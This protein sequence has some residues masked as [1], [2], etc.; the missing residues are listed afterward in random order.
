MIYFKDKNSAVSA[1]TKT[2]LLQVDRATELE[3]LLAEKEPVFLEAK[4]NV[5][6]AAKALNEAK[7]KLILASEN[8]E[9]S[10]DDEEIS[11]EYY[12]EIQRVSLLVDTETNKYNEALAIFTPVELEYQQLKSEY[13][14]IL[15][16]FF[17]IREN[18]K[19]LKKMTAKEVD[20]HLNP[21]VSKEQH[22]A[23][24]EQKKQI[25]LSEAAES[26]APLQDAVDLDI[27]TDEEIALLKEW[28]KYRVLLNRVDTSTAPDIEWPVKP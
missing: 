12:E 4:K 25:L 27:A 2:D 10:G 8:I 15:P 17:D 16:V 14:E 21:P 20:T 18:L 13:A 9:T 3:Q 6:G 26:M 28:K 1:Y 7:E 23:E 24:A 19:S 11:I 22:I 5:D